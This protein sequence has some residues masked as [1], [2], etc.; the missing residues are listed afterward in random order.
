M[1]TDAAS[2]VTASTA[3]LNGNI[4]QTEG[5]ATVRGF[6]YSTS[7]TL[8]SSVSTTTESG[9]FSS[10]GGAWTFNQDAGSEVD[11]YGVTYMATVSLWRLAETA[12]SLVIGPSF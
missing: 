4:T 5:N 1:S 10:S 11:S 9:S 7:P 12:S 6:A 3:T 2:S 8:A